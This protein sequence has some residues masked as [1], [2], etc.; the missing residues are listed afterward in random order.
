M[1]IQSGR[2]AP[3]VPPAPRRVVRR[4]WMWR[5][6]QTSGAS[7]VLALCMFFA[8]PPSSYPLPVLV[9]VG[10]TVVSAMLGLVLRFVEQP[11]EIVVQGP[12]REWPGSVIH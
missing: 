1:G 10:A 11:R 12:G 5:A 2:A 8:L 4:Q 6:L 7:A 3:I 9:L